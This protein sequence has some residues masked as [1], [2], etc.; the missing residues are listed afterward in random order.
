MSLISDVA[1]HC[2]ISGKHMGE[3]PKLTYITMDQKLI[4]EKM[5]GIVGRPTN[6][7]KTPTTDRMIVA[8]IEDVTRLYWC[9]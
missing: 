9:F 8:T 5:S 6:E 3:Y 4:T 2:G 1:A 7:D